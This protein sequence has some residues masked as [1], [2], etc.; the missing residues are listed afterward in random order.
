FFH[1]DLLPVEGVSSQWR[2]GVSFSCRLTHRNDPEEYPP[3][4]ES[5]LPYSSA[6]E[7][8]R[9]Y[10]KDDDDPMPN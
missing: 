5:R 8:E 3:R 1:P 6:K 7:P 9:E 2:Q 4:G 10:E